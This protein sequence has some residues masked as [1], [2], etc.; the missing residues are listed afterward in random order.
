VSRPPWEVA[1]IVRKA[2]SRFMDR[3]ARLLSWYQVKVLR[4]IQRCR[5]AA[6]GGHR[7]QCDHC[8]HQAISYNSCRN[9]H[10]PQCQTN[11]RNKW[12]AARQQELLPVDYYHLVF[13]L[14]HA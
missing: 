2:G 7:D 4:A 11:A 10:G 3:Y 13:S 8:G 12:L 6:L 14:P 9:R 1:D 5:T